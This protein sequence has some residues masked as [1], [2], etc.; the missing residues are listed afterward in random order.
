ME[1]C[2]SSVQRQAG[3]CKVD[4]FQYISPERNGLVTSDSENFQLPVVFR[5]AYEPA[6]SAEKAKTASSANTDR[7]YG[8]PAPARQHFNETF[9]QFNLLA[10]LQGPDKALAITKV[11]FD[12]S[13]QEADQ[14]TQEAQK[15]FYQKLAAKNKNSSG[16]PDKNLIDR[17]QTLS[18]ELAQVFPGAREKL[19][20]E[21]AEGKESGL[22]AHEEVAAAYMKIDQSDADQSSKAELI[23]S[24]FDFRAGIGDSIGQRQVFIGLLDRYGS[25]QEAR[26]HESKVQ[27][28]KDLI[29]GRFQY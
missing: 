15:T 5:D 19:M 2:L 28:Y 26:M 3:V 6:L 8:V 10:N 12:K 22:Q 7:D 13:I 16:E 29:G 21:L 9:K 25:K 4:N 23:K 14:Y 17:L 18:K 1:L 11:E 24:W 20:K 27:Q